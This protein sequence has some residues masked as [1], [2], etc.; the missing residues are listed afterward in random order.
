V[1]GLLRFFGCDGVIGEIEVEEDACNG[2]VEEAYR[3][4]TDCIEA[5]CSED[6][7]YDDSNLRVEDIFR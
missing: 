6:I 3:L 5:A 2:A 4:N 7:I 1:L